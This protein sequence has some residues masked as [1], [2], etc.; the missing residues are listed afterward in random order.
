MLDILLQFT[1]YLLL[2]AVVTGFVSAVGPAADRAL[3]EGLSIVMAVV[4]LVGYPTA[5]ETLAGGRTIGKLALGLRVVRDDGGPIRFRHALT[6]GLVRAALEWPGVLGPLTWVPSLWV[7]L[8]NPQGKRLGD[9]AAGTIVIH[10]RTPAS[11][12]WIPAMPP[13]L[14][15]WAPT[16]DLTG[17]DDQLALAV[18]HYLARNREICEP[19]RSRLGF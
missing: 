19:S 6:R 10:D 7:M 11:W 14:A 13:M 5:L 3:L 12:G 8:L 17:L 4:V 18:R 16:L 2:L 15:G 9:L 1:L